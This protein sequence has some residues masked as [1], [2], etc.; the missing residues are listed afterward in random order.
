MRLALQ[1]VGGRGDLVTQA[2]YWLE[3]IVNHLF[4]VSFPILQEESN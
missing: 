2:E 1:C 3:V 4:S